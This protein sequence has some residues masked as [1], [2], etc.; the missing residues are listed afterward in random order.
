ME[1]NFESINNLLSNR[2]E[3]A[4]IFNG[5]DINDIL[6]MDINDCDINIVIGYIDDEYV[7]K[8]MDKIQYTNTMV[9]FVDMNYTHFEECYSYEEKY[10]IIIENIVEDVGLLDKDDLDCVLKD[11]LTYE[12]I[13]GVLLPNDE[14]IRQEDS[15][16]LPESRL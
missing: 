7:D 5:R 12:L 6:D 16:E 11:L 13:G 3:R 10:N 1:I 2:Y 8:I 4:I 14:D 9:L 15:I